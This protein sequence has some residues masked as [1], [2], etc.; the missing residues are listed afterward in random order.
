LE[1]REETALQ[2][3]EDGL[4]APNFVVLLSDQQRAD[5]LGCYGQRLPVTPCLDRL[6]EDGVRFDRAFTPQPVCG[7]ARA[8]LQT[9]LYATRTGNFRND[10]PLPEGFPTLP[11]RLAHIGYDTA[12]IGKWHLASRNPDQIYHD[13]PV[14]PERRGGYDGFWMA[15]DALEISSHGYGG[16]VFD[17]DGSRVDFAG[18]RTDFLADQ[19]LT[20]LAGRDRSRPFLLFVSFLEPHQQNDTKRC[21]P[22]VDLAGRFDGYD[23]PGDLQA[24]PGNQESMYGDYLACCAAVDRSCGRVLDA[25]AEEGVLDDTLVVYASDHGCHFQTRN[26]HLGGFSEFKRSCHEASVR[27]PLLLRGPGFR[28]GKVVGTPVSLVDLLPTLLVAAGTPTLPGPPP[29]GRFKDIGTWNPPCDGLPLHTFVDA[30]DCP[31]DVFVQISES[32][33]ARSVRCGPY[34]YS[35]RAPGAEGALVSS[36]PEYVEDYLYDR[37]VDPHELQ[38][39]VK[40]PG[41]AAV[42]A[43]LRERLLGF[44]REVEGEAPAIR[45]ASPDEALVDNAGTDRRTPPCA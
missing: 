3:R 2:E 11:R 4:K 37:T 13:R 29:P 43:T 14:P 32:Q 36:A 19:A 34:T 5:S 12:Y 21:E 15:A 31:R 20:Y 23:L 40:D 17:H 22:P 7:P 39:I 30:P 38:N 41:Y 26:R 10:V 45:V 44:L 25:L 6:A 16:H 35:V 8:C 18:H 1:G 28:G 27:V 42:R 9:G 33:V 24:L